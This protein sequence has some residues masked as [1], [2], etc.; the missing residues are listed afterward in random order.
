MDGAARS[1][2]RFVTEELYVVAAGD[3]DAISGTDAND[4]GG[5]IPL[6]PVDKCRTLWGYV[7]Q[8]P[9]P[10]YYWVEAMPT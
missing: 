2:D 5:G 9:H 4:A 3:E 10:Y 8:L 1:G 6:M 7:E